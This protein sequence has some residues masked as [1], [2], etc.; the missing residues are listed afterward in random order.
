MNI[1]LPSWYDELFEFECEAKG[2]VLNF[3]VTVNSHK[4]IFNFY[5]IVR[6]T[7]DAQDEIEEYGYF[8]DEDAVILSKVTRENI[9]KYIYSQSL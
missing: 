2:S 5:D 1:V 3:D 7:Q 6:F 8:K 4:L 9:I